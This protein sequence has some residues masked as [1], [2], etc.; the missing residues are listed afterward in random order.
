[1]LRVFKP[2]SP[3]SIGS[4]LLAGYGPAAG[5][6]TASAVTG[7]LPRVGRAATAAAAALG[8]AVAAYTAALLSD[9]AVPAWHE[10]HQE[11]PYVFAGS[12]ATAAVIGAAAELVAK[13]LL[14]QRLGPAAQPYQ[15]GRAGPLMETAEVLTA[16]GLAA[17]ALGSRNRVVAAVAG[18]ALVASSALTR[19]GIFYAGRES[20]RDPKYT[21]GPQCAR[22]GGARRHPEAG[23]VPDTLAGHPSTEPIQRG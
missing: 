13:S 6:A 21:I 8:P 3:M 23:R 18:A 11:M 5:V 4:W 17:V 19:F 1:M 20:A 10:A 22:A 2:T 12:A 14:L 16:G 15:S 7:Q 9:T